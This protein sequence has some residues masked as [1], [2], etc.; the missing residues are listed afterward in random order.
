MSVHK[1]FAASDIHETVFHCKEEAVGVCRYLEEIHT[2][3]NQLHAWKMEK[4]LIFSGET[5]VWLHLTQSRLWKPQCWCLAAGDAQSLALNYSAEVAVIRSN[6]DYRQEDC[7][8][9]VVKGSWK[10]QP[11]PKAW[12]CLHSLTP[13]HILT[14]VLG[15]KHYVSHTW[16]NLPSLQKVIMAKVTESNFAV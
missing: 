8:S 6:N 7:R 9:E 16:L 14:T 11:I 10:M 3:N 12:M 5:S 1:H 2:G 13:P 4:K 15:R